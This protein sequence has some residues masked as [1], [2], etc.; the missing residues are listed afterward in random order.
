VYKV[1]DVDVFFIP[2]MM[3]TALWAAIGLAPLF[4][5]LLVYAASFG[6]ALH[7]PRDTRPLVLGGTMLLITAFVLAEPIRAAVHDFA[8]RDQSHAWG[9]YDYGHDMLD[10]VAPGGRVVGLLGETTL[11]RYFRDVLGQ[12]PDV[13]V[14]PA[15]AEPARFAAVDQTLAAGIPVY[16]TRDLPGAS[17]RY[18]LNAIGPLISVS[19]KA[20]PAAAPPG[21]T[22]GAGILLA[23]VLALLRADPEPSGQLPLLISGAYEVCVGF[24][25]AWAPERFGRRHCQSVCPEQTI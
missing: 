14:V 4:D 24:Q 16:L 19:P 22:I 12:R 3:L 1:Q 2:A 17:A 20:R 9:V 5:S 11:L 13:T 21:Q 8:K 7:L 25:L 18:S 15:D 6:R 10:S 23:D